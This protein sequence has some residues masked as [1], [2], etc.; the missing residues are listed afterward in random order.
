[1]PAH[2]VHS[3]CHRPVWQRLLFYSLPYVKEICST[4]RRPADICHLVPPVYCSRC[5]W[6]YSDIVV[7]WL[8]VCT[9]W[10]VNALHNTALSIYFCDTVANGYSVVETNCTRMWLFKDV[11]CCV[12]DTIIYPSACSSDVFL[13]CVIESWTV[14]PHILQWYVRLGAIS[15]DDR[16]KHTIAYIVSRFFL[17][18]LHVYS[19]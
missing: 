17:R 10:I 18:Q 13:V 8:P 1:M 3:R 11:L 16:T 9:D 19:K 14:Y 12:H 2:T 4:K 6:R 15:D 7:Y 5:R